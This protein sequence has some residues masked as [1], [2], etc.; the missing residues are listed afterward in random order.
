MRIKLFLFSMPIAIALLFLAAFLIAR[1]DFAKK[2]N[3]LVLSSSGDA[4]KLNPILATDSVSLEICDY[5][6]NGLLKYNENLEII[7]DLAESWNIIQDSAFY[8]DPTKGLSPEAAQAILR[9]PANAQVQAQSKITDVKAGPRGSVVLRLDT[10]G[11]AYQESLLKLLP[12]EKIVP[13]ALV[14]VSVNTEAVFRKQKAD[15]RALLAAIQESLKGA[16]DLQRNVLECL[17]ESSDLFTIKYL[18][19]AAP[20]VEHT[21]RFAEKESPPASEGKPATP[22][23]VATAGAPFLFDD[24]PVITFV[25]RKGVR[26][27][28]GQPFTSADVKFTYDTIM[29]EKTNTVRRPDFELVK[30]LETPDPHTVRV[31][32]KAPFSPCLESW[33]M[34]IIPKHLLAPEVLARQ[35]ED[36]NTASFNRHPV[37]TGPFKFLEWKTDERITV[38]ANDDYFRGRPALDRIS[39]RIIPEPELRLQEFM[40]EGI[41]FD[42]V[43]PHTYARFKEDP[44]FQVYVRPANSYNYIGWNEKE[45]MFQDVRVRRALCYAINREELVKYV[46]YGLGFVSN[47]IYPPH[48]WYYN[49]DVKPLSCDP[50]KARQLL[51]EAGWKDTNGDGILEKDGKPFRFDLIT[52]NGNP[53]RNDIAVLVQR[54]LKQVGIDVKIYLYEW[55]VFIRD[56]VE[57]RDFDACVL[58]WGLSLDPDCYQIWH[59]SQIPKGFNFVGYSNPKV[60]RLIEEGRTEFDRETRKKIYQEISAFI[61][62]DQ[63]YTFLFFPQATPALHRGAFKRKTRQP[64][65]TYKT[66]DI[67]MTKAGL[68]YYLDRW[69]RVNAAPLKQ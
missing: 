46:M 23:C 32:Y 2:I 52:N 54:Q 38:V 39:M 4:D 61:Y 13:M 14:R 41:D 18:G 24:Q 43:E 65:G 64:D 50:A 62:E 7:G 11:R 36:I 57:T 45:K 63:P 58:G 6:F 5:V 16:P 69:F 9:A 59:S 49:P 66:E 44:R 34:S 10:A 17:V 1:E 28:D 20:L 47:G 60:D 51:A 25:L 30:T 42:D 21:R 55:S 31:T 53:I 29:D 27:H 48:M 26:W 35:K 22:L 15:S 68:M 40:I 19:D 12:Q 67:E 37:G 3:E 33:A 8:P 56:K